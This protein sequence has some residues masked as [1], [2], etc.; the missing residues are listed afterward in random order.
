MSVPTRATKGAFLLRQLR[1][2]ARLQAGVFTVRQAASAGVTHATIRAQVEAGRCTRL[3]H[4]V[5]LLGNMAP[6]GPAL[7][8][9]AVLAA[10]PGAVISHETAAF[11]YG[12]IKRA[13]ELVQVSIPAHRVVRP[14]AGVR[15]RR[16]R[17]LSPVVTAGGEPPVTAPADTVL[18]LISGFRSAQDVIA[19][20]TDAIRTGRV[21]APRIVEAMQNRPRQRRVS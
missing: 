16:S 3:H 1:R 15:L 18:D 6:D 13:P 21:D 2:R 8:W 19:L 7:R 17:H 14:L 5:Y 4:G 10:G 20:L 12:F 9:A 11:G